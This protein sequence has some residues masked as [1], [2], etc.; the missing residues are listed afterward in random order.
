MSVV[1]STTTPPPLSS[2]TPRLT[3]SQ[4]PATPPTICQFP[5]N[6][7]KRIKSILQN[8]S[9]EN[10]PPPLPL[11]GAYCTAPAP[12]W[13]PFRPFGTFR[14]KQLPIMPQDSPHLSMQLKNINNWNWLNS[15]DNEASCRRPP[16]G[17]ATWD[18]RSREKKEG[19]TDICKLESKGGIPQCV[20]VYGGGWVCVLKAIR[21]PKSDCGI[22]FW[23]YA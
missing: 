17:I 1:D 6:Y 11:W 19:G 23:L 22:C 8:E 5:F 14:A 20:C 3:P 13:L 7:C 10:T 9:I 4:S 18:M 15:P 16:W 21:C 2:L 12:P